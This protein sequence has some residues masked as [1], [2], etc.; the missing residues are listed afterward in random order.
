MTMAYRPAGRP[1]LTATLAGDKSAIYPHDRVKIWLRCC[2]QK[3]PMQLTPDMEG[4]WRAGSQACKAPSVGRAP[5][6]REGAARTQQLQAH[7]STFLTAGSLAAQP[8]C[9]S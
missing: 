5:G 6:V 1:P 9:S 4:R 3:Q 7:T 8:M 2:T